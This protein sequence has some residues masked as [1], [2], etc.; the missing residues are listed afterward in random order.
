MLITGIRRETSETFDYI[1]DSY[2]NDERLLNGSA[3]YF[4]MSLFRTFAVV[5]DHM[6]FRDCDI[7]LNQYWS[8]CLQ[9][10][11]L[12]ARR[13][14]MVNGHVEPFKMIPLLGV[15]VN[16]VGVALQFVC[17]SKRNPSRWLVVDSRLCHHTES[18]QQQSYCN[19]QQSS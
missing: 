4:L 9:Q 1:L 3:T 17:R 6:D 8:G 11:R 7:N 5:F 14:V 2:A 19:C 15:H 18:V 10:L 16:H 12:F 13:L